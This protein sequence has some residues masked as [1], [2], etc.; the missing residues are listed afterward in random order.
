MSRVSPPH[1]W[2]GVI[3]DPDNQSVFRIGS[4]G[5][6]RGCMKNMEALVSFLSLWGGVMKDPENEAVCR[7]GSLW[8]FHYPLW[9]GVMKDPENKAVFRIVIVGSV[10][11]KSG[12]GYYNT[13]KMMLHLG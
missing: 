3:K 11:F 10:S 8:S 2:S 9:A 12:M 7:I 4:P 1:F 6:L 5:P 13:M